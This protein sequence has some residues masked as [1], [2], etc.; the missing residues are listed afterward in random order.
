MVNHGWWWSI[1]FDKCYWCFMDGSRCLLITVSDW[2]SVVVGIAS[3]TGEAWWRNPRKS[4]YSQAAVSHSFAACCGFPGCTFDPALINHWSMM[5]NEVFVKQCSTCWL[6]DGWW[7]NDQPIVH[8]TYICIVDLAAGRHHLL[9]HMQSI[10]NYYEYNIEA[11]FDVKSM[12]MSWYTT[13]ICESWSSC[14]FR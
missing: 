4:M 8:S 1:K 3:V 11:M 9:N 12:Y 13:H 2:R 6:H 10:E 7:V 14:G 5:G